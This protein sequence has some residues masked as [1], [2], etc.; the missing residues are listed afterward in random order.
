MVLSIEGGFMKHRLLCDL[1]AVEQ[2]LNAAITNADISR[3][4]EEYLE[5]FD[6]FYAD[7]IMVSSDRREEPVRGNASVR[8]LLFNFLVPLHVMAEVGGVKVAVRATPIPGDAPNETH[9]VWTLDLTGPF[10]AKCTLTWSVL[11]RW[12]SSRIVYEHH[13]DHHQTGGPLTF[14]DLHVG[15]L[16]VPA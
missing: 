9:S 13:Y 15:S 14:E 3:S 16:G 10:G 1:Q 11:R 4:F 2:A 8:A 7:N 12:N 6:R 5:I